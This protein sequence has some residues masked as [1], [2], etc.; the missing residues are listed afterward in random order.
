MKR[1]VHRGAALLVVLALAACGAQAEAEPEP[2]EAAPEQQSQSREFVSATGE[3][4]PAD[5]T[6]LSFATGG[7]LVELNVEVG[8]TIEEG[9]VIAELGTREL[10][11][12]LRS[13]E[14]GL[15]SAEA[16]LEQV[17]QGPSEE[18]I[19]AAEKQVAA[20]RARVGAAAAN[21]DALYSSITEDQI[22]A[23]EDELITAQQQRDDIAEALDG[24]V[25]LGEEIDYGAIPP[26]P[27]HPLAAG[28]GLAY[29]LELA[30]AQLAAA[31]ERLQ[32]LLDG[33]D[34]D[35]LQI[36]NARI[37]LAAAQADA[38]EARLAF[39]E[40]QPFEEDIV[41][42]EAQVEQARADVTAAETQLEQATLRAP[43]AGTVVDVFVDPN[44]FVA[45]GQ[46]VVQI[47]NLDT[48]QVETTDLNE[49]DVASI[50]EGNTVIIT[51]DALP[52]LEVEGTVQR[53]APKSSRGTGVNYTATITMEDVPDA[54]RWGMTAFVDI[55]VNE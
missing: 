26:G 4:L 25:E 40:S 48:L 3:V 9:D 27:N 52:Q 35:Q 2:E 12:A 39:I 31:G 51:F 7:E 37:G 21:R 38:A 14:A 32:D 47:G 54:V 49:L 28:E 15:A 45:P 11:A 18:Q 24:L 55:R 10:E 44:E 30:D 13:A 53:I 8:D 41:I 34:P 50:S 29:Q 42:A 23:A 33:P 22:T 46:D 36:A 5:Y 1:F 6:V 43:F 19:D 17:R 20:A 16:Q